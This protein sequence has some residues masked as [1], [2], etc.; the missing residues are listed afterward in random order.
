MAMVTVYY[1]NS[2][3]IGS[4]RIFL[5]ILLSTVYQTEILDKYF[6]YFN[7]IVA[8]PS[9]FAREV[10][11]QKLFAWNKLFTTRSKVKNLNYNLRS[12]STP[13]RPDL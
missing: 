4:T 12:L 1:T 11:F 6:S 3:L 2:T 7:T 9:V 8:D 13:P 5:L 10:K